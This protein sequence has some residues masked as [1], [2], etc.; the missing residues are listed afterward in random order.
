VTD[1]AQLHARLARFRPIDLAHLP[2]PLEPMERLSKYLGGP[3]LW[4]KRDHCTVSNKVRKLSY[5][6]RDALEAGADTLVSGG[7]VQSNS[8]RQ[9]AVAAA[10][11]GLACHLAV[12]HGRV[13]PSAPQFATSGNVALNQLFGAVLHDVPRAVQA[14][15]WQGMVQVDR[16]GR[17]QRPADSQGPRPYEHPVEQERT[18]MILITGASGNVGTELA[19]ALA[20]RRVPFRAMV[21]APEA[22]QKVEGLAGVELV[23][24]DFND[25]AT[26]ARALT[27]ITRAFLLTPSSEQAEAQQSAF[28]DSAR[29]AGVQ[30]I[31]K[32]SPGSHHI[33]LRGR[34]TIPTSGVIHRAPV[35]RWHSL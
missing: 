19:R 30:H 26:I 8:Q 27:G 6:L 25:S 10:R 28:V 7:T 13:A 31:V 11:L 15:H 16:R 22:A 17:L 24:G 14:L 29:R 23:Q 21:R 34:H 4:V 33:S 9:V 3:S 1:S 20:T 35:L 2:T 18:P 32:V 12:Y 5:V